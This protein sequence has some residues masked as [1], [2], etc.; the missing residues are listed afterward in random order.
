MSSQTAARRGG[1]SPAQ[2]GR[3][4][5]GELRRPSFEHLCRAA[6]AV[7]LDASLKA[8]PSAATVRDA[9]QLAVLAR[10]EAM[11]AVPLVLGREAALPAV[12]DQRAWDGKIRGA[13]RPAS[14][15][16]EVHLHDLQAMTRRIALKTRDDPD[17]GAVILVVART[18]H[19]R[20]VLAEH[21]E[22]LRVQFPLDGAAIA[23]ELRAGRVPRESGI[24]LV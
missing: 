23:R 19:N 10:F 1:L 7:G 17:A 13:D 4:E 12:G 14:I 18:A 3:I 9:G 24:I 21:R 8:Y 16:C 6:R 11:L 20:R 22:S 5:R 2:H 15:E